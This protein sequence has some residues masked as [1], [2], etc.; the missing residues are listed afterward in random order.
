MAHHERQWL[1]QNVWGWIGLAALLAAPAVTLAKGEP[2]GPWLLLNAAALV[3]LVSIHLHTRL[4]ARSLRV[5]VFP[6]WRRTVDLGAVEAA[7]PITYRFRDFGGW[8]IRFGAGAVA[9]SIAGDQAVRLRLTGEKRDLVIGTRDA[10]RLLAEL[11]LAGVTV[12][13]T[14]PGDD[15]AAA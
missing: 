14:E 10:G 5:G 15:A 6:L 12:Q 11:S 7:W 1:I 8:G 4:E 3:L 9:Y 13:E 2:L